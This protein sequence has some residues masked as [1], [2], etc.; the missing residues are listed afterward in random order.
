MKSRIPL[1][2]SALVL[3]SCATSVPGAS[4]APAASSGNPSEPSGTSSQAIPSETSAAPASSATS[5]PAASLNPSSVTEPS[6]P[7]FVDVPVSDLPAKQRTFYQLLVY[8]FADGNGDGIGDFKGIIDNLDYLEKLGVGGIW[9]S[10]I[11]KAASYHAYDTIDYYAVNPSYEV[12]VN[13]VKYDLAKLLEACHAK[14]IKVLMDMVLN[15]SH[16]TCA[17][18]SQHSDWYKGPDAFG[19]TMKDFNYDNTALRTEIKNVGKYWLNKGV[20]GY[21][22][23]AAKWI[24][25]YGGVYDGADDAKNFVW[26]KEF[27][28]ACKAVKSDV[29]MVAEV[30]VE[31]DI[32][33]DRLYAKTQMDSNFNFELRDA[34]KRAIGGNPSAYVSHLVD[35]QTEIRNNYSGAIEAACLSNHDI[36][37]FN[38]INSL[39]P[40]KQALAGMMNVLA[41]GDSYVYYG[42]ELGLTGT[43]ENGYDD[44]AYRTAMPMATGRTN[45]VNYFAG[46]HGNGK[47]TTRTISGQ[48]AQTDIA[49]SSS[50][51]VDYADAIKA[52][53]RAKTLYNGKVRANPTSFDGQLGSFITS[54]GNDSD[55]VI[56]NTSGTAKLVSMAAGNKTLI[57][58]SAYG[59][60]HSGLVDGN[61]YLAPYSCAV[62]SG[63]VEFTASVNL[64]GSQTSSAASSKPMPTP[65]DFGTRVTTEKSGNLTLHFAN[66]LGWNTV[67]AY[68]WVDQKTYLGS[69]P[70]QSITN[71]GDGWYTVRIS[72]GATNIIFN[73]GNSQTVD[74]FRNK[75]GEY[76]FVPEAGGSKPTG[77]WYA[78][79][80]SL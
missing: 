40:E 15:H 20:D 68:A 17:W 65:D 62:F 3:A 75:E 12:T 8:S 16:N 80:P 35:Y 5:T 64:D 50:L 67:N 74:L 63:A 11:C 13:G 4:S 70:G 43:T 10:P 55:T 21:R 78:T 19:G 61:L 58:E 22:L 1:I 54:Y 79:K 37:R 45:S 28:D 7:S 66:V 31:N 23:D 47:S 27:Y 76:W 60:H 29:Y 32:R 59:N 33:E 34:V 36:G 52:K 26:W 72:Q 51:A 57:G 18:V 30:L 14:G 48:T 77:N 38:Q 9:L 49:N 53:N 73:D 39:T 6:A 71:D 44:M 25:N 2:L 41:P 46:F 24:Y 56:F 69:W 42:D